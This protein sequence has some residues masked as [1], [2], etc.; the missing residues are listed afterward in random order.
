VREDKPLLESWALVL[1]FALCAASLWSWADGFSECFGLFYTPG[2][3]G[4]FGGEEHRRVC[5]EGYD[6]RTLALVSLSLVSVAWIV[7]K[8]LARKRRR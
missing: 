3:D 5:I 2:L 8:R 1:V 6:W 7:A 4:R